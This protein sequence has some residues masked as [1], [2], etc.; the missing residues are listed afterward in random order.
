MTIREI[1]ST[2]M[3][4]GTR[5]EALETKNALPAPT[6]A[7][8]APA[9]NAPA[10]TVE[11]AEATI[12][13][14]TARIEAIETAQA[15]ATADFDSRLEAAITEKT[16]TLETEFQT[17]VDARAAELQAD[18]L[19]SQGHDPLKTGA[20]TEEDKSAFAGLKGRALVSAKIAAE[21]K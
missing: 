8:N 1:I 2:V 3:G 11:G 10:E 9:E 12:T 14:M 4:L 7:E 17:K 15:S 6:P 21:R 5:V 16:A 13:S 19:A 18:F 20:N